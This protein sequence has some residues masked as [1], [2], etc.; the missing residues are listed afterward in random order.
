MIAT[1]PVAILA[2]VT[3]VY[4]SRVLIHGTKTT[5]RLGWCQDIGEEGPIC[6]R[7][8]YPPKPCG[9]AFITAEKPLGQ[10]DCKI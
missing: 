4:E 6:S 10:L 3:R 8:E 1:S 9:L 5:M 2:S 7:P